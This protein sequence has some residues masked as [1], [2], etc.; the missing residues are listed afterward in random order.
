MHELL[1][2]EVALLAGGER[3]LLDLAGDPLLLVERERDGLDRRPRTRLCGASTAG[4]TTC[5][6]GVEEVLHHHHRVVPLLDRLAVEVRRELGQRLRVVVDGDRDVLLRGREL[7]RDLLVEGAGG[8]CD[9]GRRVTSGRESPRLA[10]ARRALGRAPGC[11]ASRGRWAD[12]APRPA[13]SKT[14]LARARSPVASAHGGHPRHAQGPAL[15]ARLRLEPDG[16]V[17][18]RPR[19]RAEGRAGAAQGSSGS[20]PAARSG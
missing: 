8:N 7:V 4:T 16:P 6:V 13:A 20:S 1:R 9:M 17:G 19:R 2:D 10:L 18:A 3:E 11:R 15:H 5:L 12:R 14:L